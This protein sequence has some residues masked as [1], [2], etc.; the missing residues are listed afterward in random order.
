[1]VKAVDI[2]KHILVPKHVKLSE[3]DKEKLLEKYNIST[4]QLP[5]ILKNDSAI[6]DLKLKQGDVVKIIRKS[7]TA[8]DIEFYRGVANG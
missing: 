5:R 8:G 2:K 4:T 7:P 3:K 1:M 6:K